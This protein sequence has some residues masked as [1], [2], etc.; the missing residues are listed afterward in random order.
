MCG[1]GARPRAERKGGEADGGG[2][3]RVGTQPGGRADEVG[4]VGRPRSGRPA[5]E[6]HS[7]FHVRA[8]R[9]QLLGKLVGDVVGELGGKALGGEETDHRGLR[10]RHSDAF[11]RA[12]FRLSLIPWTPW[13]GST[14]ARPFKA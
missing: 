6:L 7:P 13:W 8:A 2:P 3:A 5:I 10:R 12:V 4:F 14:N 9:A 11:T 1:D